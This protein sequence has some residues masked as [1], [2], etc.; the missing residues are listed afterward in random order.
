MRFF[1]SITLVTLAFTA[2][3]AYASALADP[4]PSC[5]PAGGVCE[6]IVGP[7]GECCAGKCVEQ[8]VSIIIDASIVPHLSNT[9]TFCDQPDLGV[10]E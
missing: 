3:C 9:L 1:T 7:V 10:C 8:A 6:T 2:L 4:P 5:I